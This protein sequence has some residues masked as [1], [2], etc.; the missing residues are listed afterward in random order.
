MAAGGVSV[1]S[2]SSPGSICLDLS[3]TANN[4]D[5]CKPVVGS[6]TA[7]RSFLP[8]NLGSEFGLSY[9]IVETFAVAAGIT[10]T[11]YLNGYTLGFSSSFLFHPTLT[12][13]FA[14]NALP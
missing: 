6:V 1:N 11:Y 9:S 13:I 10:Y 2:G 7:W 14:P 4:I 5:G 8:A 3:D 12:A